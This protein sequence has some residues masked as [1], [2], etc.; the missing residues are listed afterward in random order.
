M[1]KQRRMVAD[2]AIPQNQTHHGVTIQAPEMMVVR[3]QEAR[4]VDHVRRSDRTQAD[5][6]F[7]LRVSTTMNVDIGRTVDLAEQKFKPQRT[8]EGTLRSAIPSARSEE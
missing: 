3:T 1:R 7:Q 4:P 8:L 2:I 5:F 6:W